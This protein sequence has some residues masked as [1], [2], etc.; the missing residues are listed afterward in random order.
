MLPLWNDRPEVTSNLVNPA[1]CSILLAY[2]VDGYKAD[3]TKNLPFALSFFV[4]PFIL[5]SRIRLTLPKTKAT[6]MHAWI[7]SNE[8][9]RITLGLQVANYLP[10]T[11]EAIMFGI[12]TNHLSIDDD[13]GLEVKKKLRLK[14]EDEEIKS[15]LSKA[16]LLGK[17]L[18]KG[19]STT[20]V[21]SLL[22]LKP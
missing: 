12:T 19:G 22:G 8:E 3:T 1:F 7:N 15:C 16:S 9:L 20:T 18:A 4:L 10:F 5:N 21:F 14:S 11:K 17:L 6:T 13:G 2:S